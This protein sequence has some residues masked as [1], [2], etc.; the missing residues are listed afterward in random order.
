MNLQGP[1][2]HMNPKR[3][4]AP[5]ELRRFEE[6]VE[7]EFY[8]HQSGRITPKDIE[9]ACKALEISYL[10]ANLPQDADEEGIDVSQFIEFATKCRVEKMFEEEVNILFRA[11]GNGAE[12]ITR[13]AFVETLNS[14]PPI[15]LP[16]R[17]LDKMIEMAG[18]F[19]ITRPNFVQLLRDIGYFGEKFRQIPKKRSRKAR[20]GPDQ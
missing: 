10:P 14:I 3:P 8:R 2:K 4:P 6:D 18:G 20:K 17:V 9:L 16:E 5:E 19:P 12:C 7:N 15:R 1:P 13:E 11:L